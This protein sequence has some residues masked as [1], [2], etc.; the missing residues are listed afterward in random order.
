[1]E[2][3][4]RRSRQNQ[5]NEGGP[6]DALTHSVCPFRGIEWEEES[7]DSIFA[8]GAAGIF[9]TAFAEGVGEQPQPHNY[10]HHKVG[11]CEKG[12]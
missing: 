11:A 9:W 6:S 5:A 12:R 1:M 2:T 10:E 4:R 3:K 8:V 7:G